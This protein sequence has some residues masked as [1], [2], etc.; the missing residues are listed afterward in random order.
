MI[1]LVLNCGSSSAKFAVIDPTTG[2]EYISGLAQRLGSPHASLDWKVD[3]HKH[4]RVLHQADHD[5]ALR[6]VVDLLK[7]L[8]LADGL[9]L[10]VIVEKVK[11]SW[12]S[13]KRAR[14]VRTRL[15]I[16]YDGK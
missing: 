7:E 16:L 14:S 2:R 8:E 3:G 12:F 13:R 6:I 4:S 5:A 10:A 9:R 11:M 15:V 1:V